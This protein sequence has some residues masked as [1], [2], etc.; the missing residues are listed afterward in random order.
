MGCPKGIFACNKP[1]PEC[2]W[3]VV[4]NVTGM[5]AFSYCCNH[6]PIAHAY[7][8]SVF[9]QIGTYAKRDLKSDF[10]T[11]WESTRSMLPVP[12]SSL[13]PPLLLVTLTKDNVACALRCERSATSRWYTTRS[14]MTYRNQTIHEQ[15]CEIPREDITK[16]CRNF[17]RLCAIA[18][19]RNL[20]NLPCSQDLEINALA[21]SD[22]EQHVKR[23]RDDTMSSEWDKST[24][25]ERTIKRHQSNDPL[26]TLANHAIRELSHSA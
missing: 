1:C 26:M 9:E 10:D 13:P 16:T 18:L 24:G 2:P 4:V 22:L 3:R 12:P 15:E 7:L 25:Q 21:L 8:S 17:P 20:R 19:W 11:F 23:R 5:C 6:E 14:K